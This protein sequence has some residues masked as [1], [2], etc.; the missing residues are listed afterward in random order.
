MHASDQHLMHES[1]SYHDKVADMHQRITAAFESVWERTGWE[2]QRQNQYSD[3][4]VYLKWG[5]LYGCG[6]LLYPKKKVLWNFPQCMAGSTHQSQAYIGQHPL[7]SESRNR[8][9][10]AV[11]LDCLKL[12]NPGL[13]IEK[14]ALQ[15]SVPV[16]TTIYK[17][18][19]IS[20]TVDKPCVIDVTEEDDY[21]QVSHQSKL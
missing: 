2:Q 8:W 19:K 1:V 12:C 9:L 3:Q 21:E 5:I 17:L 7:H 18:Q 16:M 10:Q 14:E 20:P 11:N 15:Q 13:R 4:D 6:I